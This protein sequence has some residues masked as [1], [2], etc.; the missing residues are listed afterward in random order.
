[1]L[2]SAQPAGPPN[3]IAS[4]TN[5]VFDMGMLSVTR[6]DCLVCSRIGT[7]G[8]SYCY[9]ERARCKYH[10]RHSTGATRRSVWET[11]NVTDSFMSLG[12]HERSHY[13]YEDVYRCLETGCKHTY[14]DWDGLKRHTR[15]KHCR[16]PRLYPC[17]EIGCKYRKNEFKRRDKRNDHYI[18]VH[19]NRQASGRTGRHIQPAVA[20]ANNG[21]GYRA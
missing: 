16:N 13:K 6:C 9:S 20:N 15:G 7:G 10:Y 5:S 8:K 17:P 21:A 4:L 18:K 14:A 11:C 3:G 1:M 12:D 2:V 19:M